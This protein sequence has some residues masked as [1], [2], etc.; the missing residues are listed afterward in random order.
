MGTHMQI[1]T[2]TTID[3]PSSI[4]CAQRSVNKQIKSKHWNLQSI[5]MN[6]RGSQHE[7]PMFIMLMDL[8]EPPPILSPPSSAALQSVQTWTNAVL[9][10]AQR[11]VMYKNIEIVIG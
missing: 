7:I 5:K 2:R 1:P 10:Y 9:L 11:L 6:I 4:D 3:A 8:L